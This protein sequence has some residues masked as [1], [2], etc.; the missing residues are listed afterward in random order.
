MSTLKHVK[1]KNVSFFNNAMKYALIISVF[2]I[3][4]SL[5]YYILEVEVFNWGFI[6]AN[7]VISIVIIVGAFI[8]G[9]KNYRNNGLGGK[10][11]FGQAFLHSLVIGFIAYAIIAIYNYVFYAFIAPEY[12]ASMT[13]SFITFMESMNIP[14]DI[15]EQSIKDFEEQ[16]TP[17]GQLLSGLKNGAVMSII[18][19]LIVGLAIKKDTTQAEIS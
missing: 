14:E 10:I 9:V 2:S 16:M 12:A 8:F 5:I 6:A 11:T 3:I 18:V 19:A 1:M 7:F 17:M 13:D 4:L 15:L